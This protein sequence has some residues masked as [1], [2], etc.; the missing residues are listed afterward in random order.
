MS[1]PGGNGRTPWTHSQTAKEF[2]A[3]HKHAP[4]S[5]AFN[6][7]LEAEA[8]NPELDPV[9]RFMAAGTRLAWGHLS[10]IIVDRMPPKNGDGPRQRPMNQK[11]L[12]EW[13]VIGESALSDAISEAEE[14]GFC[15]RVSGAIHD[16]GIG[17]LLSLQ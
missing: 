12:A 2:H 4:Y 9:H 10:D 15:T 3:G 13:M 1:A 7:R 17:H 11:Q 6:A 8:R 16:A 5:M 14:L